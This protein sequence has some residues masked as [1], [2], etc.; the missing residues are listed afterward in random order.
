MRDLRPELLRFERP[1]GGVDLYDPLLERLHRFPSPEIPEAELRARLLVASPEIDRIRLQVY[2][3]HAQGEPRALCWEEAAPPPALFELAAELPALVTPRW[4]RPEP[5]R[6]LT[7]ERLAGRRV[8]LLQEF[9][10]AEPA[11]A[12]ATALQEGPWS[13]LVTERVSADRYQA[14][15]LPGPM[16]TLRELLLA[17]P[18]RALMG[19]A[20]GVALPA[21]LQL[22]GWRL[23]PGDRFRVHPDG[24]RYAATFA[25]GL[26]EA[27]AAADGGAIAFGDPGPDGLAVRE[28]WLPFLGDLCCFAPDRT[29]WHQVEPPA[30]PRLTVSG[31]WLL[32]SG[33]R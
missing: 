1:D 33:A 5:W 2:H 23:I 11:R 22:N 31:W 8:Q 3:A 12:L 4:R 27:W 21:A 20:L 16:L 17:D 10:E 24:R 19:A 15:E 7:E 14:A 25:I 32:G 9:L 6:R 29:S 18:L 28:R 30:R 26:N 13:R